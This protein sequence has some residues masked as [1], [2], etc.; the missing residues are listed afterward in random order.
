MRRILACALAFATPFAAASCEDQSNPRTFAPL[1]EEDAGVEEP[2]GAISGDPTKGILMEGTVIGESGPF[3]GMVL[4]GTDG[5]IACAEP[6]DVC[7]SDPKAEGAARFNV[8][9]V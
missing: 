5:V 8:V 9:G 2:D 4:V 7:A 6:G 3:E 1:P